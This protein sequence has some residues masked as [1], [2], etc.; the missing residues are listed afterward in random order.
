MTRVVRRLS[1]LLAGYRERAYQDELDGWADSDNEQ[2]IR[3]ALLLADSFGVTA[4]VIEAANAQT[5]SG[6]LALPLAREV[7]P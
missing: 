3:R 2:G 5:E 7:Q 1:R 4:E 6:Q